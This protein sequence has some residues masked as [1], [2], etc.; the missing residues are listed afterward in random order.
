[1]PFD[2]TNAAICGAKGG[3][4]GGT[5]RSDLKA[6]HARVNGMKGG[7]PR[8]LPPIPEGYRLSPELAKLLTPHEW[9]LHVRQFPEY[10]AELC[11]RGNFSPEPF[12]TEEE[13]RE[14]LRRMGRYDLVYRR[15]QFIDQLAKRRPRRALPRRYRTF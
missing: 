2:S 3:K 8:K 9:R 11:A 13:I 6:A 7:R 14:T 10:V 15:K 4:I 1:M 12:F 5:H